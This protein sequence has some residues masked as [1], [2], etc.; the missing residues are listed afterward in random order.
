M[1]APARSAAA[2]TAPASGPT[3]A[4]VAPVRA[5]P[6]S[7]LDRQLAGLESAIASARG[8]VDEG[9]LDRLETG[10]HRSSARLRLSSSHTIVAIAGS[11]GS[12]KSTLFNALA[13]TRLSAS[14]AQRP[15]TSVANAL[16]WSEEDCAEMLD[17]LG[18][19]AA[20]RHLRA[21]LPTGR[22]RDALPEGLVL[23]DLPDHDSIEVAHHAEAQRVVEMA[24]LLIW[25][26][27]PQKYADAAIH[28]RF[29]QPLSGHRAVT[30]VVL[31]HI[32]EVPEERRTGMLRDLRKLLVADG[33]K[34]PRVLATSAR[35]G[36]GMSE[37][38]TAIRR[39]VEQKQHVALRVEA[40]VRSAA[41]RLA[42]AT[43]TAPTTVPDVWISDL[44]RRVAD[45]ARVGSRVD[46]P[47]V[48]TAVRAL[49]DNVCR[50]LTPAWSD[51]I[52]AAATERLKET[53]DRLDAELAGLRFQQRPPGWLSLLGP[54]TGVASVAAVASVVLAGVAYVGGGALTL[55]LVAVGVTVALAVVLAVVA[56]SARTRADAE[57]D[58]AAETERRRVA[59]RVLRAHVVAPVNAE[60]ASYARLRRGLD[61]AKS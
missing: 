41:D 46:R 43:G 49:V 6:A 56:R 44:E 9:L 50:D 61:A 53:D 25:V 48:D 15:T 10:V 22:G 24:D 20:R 28:H 36:A 51:P 31:N 30:M 52:R 12:G 29:L 34:D 58:R 32:D 7:P 33:M 17:W 54:A 57:L 27:D 16:V 18:V 37:L 59:G 5:A 23:L 55:P 8:R 1:V 60:L 47:A 14:G 38:R 2:P 13:G 26:V 39:R 42:K 3:A 40:D 4:A 11:T 45:A 19:P 35:H 21:D